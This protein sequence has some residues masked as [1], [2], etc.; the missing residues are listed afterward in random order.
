MR[1]FKYIYLTSFLF[2]AGCEAPQLVNFNVRTYKNDNPIVLNVGA[3][4]VES[5]VEKFDRLPHVEEKMP[6][7]P[8]DALYEWAGHHFRAG[9][10]ES[11][12]VF[13]IKI[14]EAYMTQTDDPSNNWYT[15]DNVAYKLSYSVDLTFISQGD[16]IYSHDMTGWE[17]ASLPK[18]ASMLDKEATWLKMMNAMTKKVNERAPQII[19]Q[20]FRIYR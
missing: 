15:F 13:M 2:L 7:T 1:F 18:R 3:I 11:D 20:Q 16:V 19:P 12:K 4:E 14:K 9:K 10:P 8:E 6:M 5:E 17:S